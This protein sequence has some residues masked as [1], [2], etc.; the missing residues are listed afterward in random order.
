MDNTILLVD[1]NKLFIEIQKEFLQYT[2]TDILTAKD[3]LEALEV[4][5]I[6]QPDL[7]FMDYEMPRM[8]GA[9][10]CRTIKSNSAL[11]NIP[12]VMVTSKGKE[13]DIEHCYSM[14]CDHFITK[15][16]DRDTFLSIARKF[17]PNIDRR[18]RRIL[19]GFDALLYFRDDKVSCK[20]LDLSAGGAYVTTDYFG[21]PNSVVQISF[22][23]PDGT[24]IDCHGRIAWVNRI[25]AKFPRGIGIKF[26]LMS[27]HMQDALNDFI[28]TYK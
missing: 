17:I 21:T 27:K 1:D 2:N 3:G 19:V 5:K 28:D 16:L 12:V 13:E 18:E 14:G 20:L 22:S 11:A 8:D 7:V 25:Y 24:T 15:P 4:L 9:T 6:K 23:L 10:C 26:A